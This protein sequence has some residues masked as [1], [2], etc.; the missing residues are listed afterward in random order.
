MQRRL[1]LLLASLVIAETCERTPRRRVA[2]QLALNFGFRRR[3]PLGQHW[4]PGHSHCRRLQPVCSPCPAQTRSE[5]S[6]RG[7]T[8]TVRPTA[9]AGRWS[10]LTEVPRLSGKDQIR[11]VMLSCSAPE[12]DTKVHA[13]NAC[14]A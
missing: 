1:Q 5:T 13:C 11:D 3:C 10:Q 4:I 2:A 7:T 8:G 6:V 12:R 14:K 9:P